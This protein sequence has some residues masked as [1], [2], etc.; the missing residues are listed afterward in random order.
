MEP[1]TRFTET[2]TA[3]ILVKPPSLLRGEPQK[4]KKKKSCRLE[5]ALK[6][7]PNM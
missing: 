5:H 7:K 1:Q 2:W 6:M 4:K 3:K